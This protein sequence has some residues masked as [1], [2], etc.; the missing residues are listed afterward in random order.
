MSS[1][2]GSGLIDLRSTAMLQSRDRFSAD[3]ASAGAA[4]AARSWPSRGNERD[5]F[6][7]QQLLQAGNL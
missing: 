7:S 6:V 5:S 4:R 2:M 3:Q 1:F